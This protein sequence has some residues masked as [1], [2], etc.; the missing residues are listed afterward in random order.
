MDIP[1]L[2]DHLP[3]FLRE[4]ALLVALFARAKLFILVDLAVLIG[5]TTHLYNGVISN[6][7]SLARLVYPS[8]LRV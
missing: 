2:V 4:F 7:S 6:G 5:A 1:S 8:S 3:S